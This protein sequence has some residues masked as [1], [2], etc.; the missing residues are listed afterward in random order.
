MNAKRIILRELFNLPIDASREDILSSQLRLPRMQK[1]EVKPSKLESLSKKYSCIPSEFLSYYP[2]G[3]EFQ[4]EKSGDKMG[5]TNVET[6]GLVGMK[7]KKRGPTP[8][9]KTSKNTQ[10]IV[11][12][13]A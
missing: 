10:S 6:L 1:K 4:R 12:V 11:S 8:V 3:D 5:D 13:Y 9:L 7:P 2:G